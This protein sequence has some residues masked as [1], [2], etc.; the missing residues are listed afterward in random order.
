[1][2][3][4]EKKY[5]HGNDM[6]GLGTKKG[7]YY[8]IR[9]HLAAKPTELGR[10]CMHSAM[11]RESKPPKLG[12][13][14]CPQCETSGVEVHTCRATQ[15]IYCS[16]WN[17]QKK[18]GVPS[19]V[20]PPKRVK[21]EEPPVELGEVATASLAAAAATIP[22]EVDEQEAELLNEQAFLD[23]LIKEL[24]A[25]LSRAQTRRARIERLLNAR[26]KA[27]AVVEVEIP[28]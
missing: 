11:Q 14:Y 9:S 16:R 19:V 28:L 27:T 4:T 1:M 20:N 17:C 12:D 18:A 3:P 13:G 23:A 10:G 8:R 25:S 21:K 5:A 24:G 6:Q 15:E 2:D 26:R 22:I 7:S